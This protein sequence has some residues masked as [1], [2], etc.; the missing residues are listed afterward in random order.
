MHNTREYTSRISSVFDINKSH[1][2]I[3]LEEDDGITTHFDYTGN[4][5]GRSYLIDREAGWFIVKRQLSTVG[6]DMSYA[7]INIGYLDR[8]LEPNFLLHVGSRRNER[9]NPFVYLTYKG[10]TLVGVYIP[11]M[12]TDCI[13]L[14]TEV[15]RLYCSKTLV[16]TYL[17][18]CF[19]KS[20]TTL[21]PLIF[22][23]HDD[24]DD[25]DPVVF[26]NDLQDF[27][28]GS[29][30]Y[31]ENRVGHSGSQIVQRILKAL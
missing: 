2:S 25:D 22:Y 21:D 19:G 13:M 30:S 17:S 1:E 26:D 5:Q 9:M 11:Y 4:L 18:H 7:Y 15:H 23:D 14:E 31:C 28:V 16:K 8:D 20:S 24:D 27:R 10:S 6:L 3:V 12:Y 29:F